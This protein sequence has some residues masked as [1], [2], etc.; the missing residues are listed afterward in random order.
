[1]QPRIEQ[2]TLLASRMLVGKLGKVVYIFVDDDVQIVGS[3][4]CRNVGGG[5]TFGHLAGKRDVNAER[6][7]V[8]HREGYVVTRRSRTRAVDL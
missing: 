3:L 7:E 6:V 5:E 8:W 4:V 1:M 2:H